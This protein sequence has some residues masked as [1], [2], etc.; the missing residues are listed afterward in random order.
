MVSPPVLAI[1]NETQPRRRGFWSFAEPA[2]I[3]A[4]Q[5]NDYANDKS[6]GLYLL[7]LVRS[8]V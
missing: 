6:E 1:G 2:A 3:E 7:P 5:K 8:L 4:K